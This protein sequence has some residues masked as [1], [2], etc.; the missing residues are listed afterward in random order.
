MSKISSFERGFAIY[1][2]IWGI[3]GI[4]GGLM[5]I[6]M[7]IFSNFISALKLSPMQMLLA[8]A[9][10]A[11]SALLITTAIYILQNKPY[12]T[13]FKTT[14][15]VLVGYNLLGA[16]A[17]FV[18]G[19]GMGMSFIGLGMLGTFSSGL[20]IAWWLVILWLFSRRQ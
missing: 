15:A 19:M 18:P 10:L 16:F 7:L 13:I 5:M 20:G 11:A 4:L 3:I 9:S 12:W 17:L 2:L 8:G 1:F 6:G 14:I